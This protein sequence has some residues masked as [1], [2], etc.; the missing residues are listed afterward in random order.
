[1]HDELVDDERCQSFV[2]LQHAEIEIDDIADTFKE[3]YCLIK[4]SIQILHHLLHLGRED[5]PEEFFLCTEIIMDEGLIASYGLGYL[6][7]RSAAEPLFQKKAFS[8][9]QDSFFYV[10][11]SI[12]CAVRR[13]RANIDIT[14][15]QSK[16]SPLRK[17]AMRQEV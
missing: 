6:C 10:L 5:I 2:Q 7:S 9:P 12:H 8:N 14:F 16:A 3:I 17:A 15:L 13:F 11:I 1:M 4:R